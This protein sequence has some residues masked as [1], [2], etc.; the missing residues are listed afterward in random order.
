[1]PA[2]AAISACSAPGFIG[3]IFGPGRFAR[4][5]KLGGNAGPQLNIAVKV[6]F[7]TVETKDV[8]IFG[9]VT[10]NSSI[11][12]DKKARKTLR[13]IVSTVQV[14]F[15]PS[16]IITGYTEPVADS[17]IASQAVAATTPADQARFV[18]F[19]PACAA[20]RFSYTITASNFGAGTV[21]FSMK[22][23]SDTPKFSP[24]GDA[25]LTATLSGNEVGEVPVIVVIPDA[26][27]TPHP[28]FGPAAVAGVNVGLD[29]GTSPAAL[30]FHR[31]KSS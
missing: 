12:P 14:N 4:L 6:S 5:V 7:A 27:G 22:G 18:N 31:A 1:M 11:D 21:Q 25:S 10:Y 16:P 24:E 23:R 20:N 17:T 30:A 13:V 28:Q 3:T 19:A 26:I 15:T 2:P 9:E 8:T 29:A